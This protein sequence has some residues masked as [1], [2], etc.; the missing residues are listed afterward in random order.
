MESSPGSVN[1]EEMM[2]AM[3]RRTGFNIFFEPESFRPPPE[4]D[5]TANPNRAIVEALGDEELDEY[6]RALQGY[7]AGDFDSVNEPTEAAMENACSEVARRSAGP[8]PLPPARLDALDIEQL[9]I[10]GDKVYRLTQADPRLDAAEAERVACL[11]DQGLPPYPYEYILGL[12]RSETE[13]VT[14]DPQGYIDGQGTE[15]GMAEAFGADR[16]R[17]LQAEELAAA[18]A[19]NERAMPKTRV[20][21]E[22]ITE[23]EQQI[24]AENPD[25][26]ALLDQDQ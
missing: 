21:R 8:E 25:I 3:A 18:I 4:D 19:G 22:L 2:L 5:V 7:A 13:R 15:A 10:L 20:K 1:D 6:W 14:G 23:Y 26:A 17:E 11:A 12:L 16:L 24:L 9:K